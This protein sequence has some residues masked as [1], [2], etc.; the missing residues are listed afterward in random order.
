MVFG[1]VS[2]VICARWFFISFAIFVFFR[3]RITVT[4]AY[5][6]RCARVR[7]RPQRRISSSHRDR[8]VMIRAVFIGVKYATFTR[9]FR[10]SRREYTRA[11]VPADNERYSGWQIENGTLTLVTALEM[12]RE[13]VEFH[14]DPIRYFPRSLSANILYINTL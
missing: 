11:S 4:L 8:P 2:L 10:P 1:S 13:D 6:L 5:V 14:A 9:S 12:E 3:V 7:S